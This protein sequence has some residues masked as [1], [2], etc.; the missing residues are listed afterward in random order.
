MSLTID[1][2][3][4]AYFDELVAF[5]PDSSTDEQR[6]ALLNK[7]IALIDKKTQ[8]K[9]MTMEDIVDKNAKKVDT[10]SVDLPKFLISD[11]EKAREQVD[12]MNKSR[13]ATNKAYRD[14]VKTIFTTLIK[15]A[16]IAAV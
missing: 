10:G 4:L 11:I 1:D 7:G 9:P 5:N 3:I 2:S 8:K 6:L 15:L 14:G 16:A 13:A 12:E